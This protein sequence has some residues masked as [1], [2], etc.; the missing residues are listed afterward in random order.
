VLRRSGHSAQLRYLLCGIFLLLCL[1]CAISASGPKPPL[2]PH[3][4]CCGAARHCGLSL[5]PQNQEIGEFTVCGQTGLLL[6]QIMQMQHFIA[7][8]VELLLRCSPCRGSGHSTL[9][10]SVHVKPTIRSAWANVC[11]C[12][13]MG[14]LIKLVADLGPAIRQFNGYMPASFIS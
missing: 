14:Q 9:Q 3:S 2:N 5:Q 4:E 13:L 10:I 12:G 7:V 1:F 6:A 8:A 11:P